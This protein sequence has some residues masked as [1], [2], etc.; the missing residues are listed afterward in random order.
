MKFNKKLLSLVVAVLVLISSLTAGISA[1]AITNSISLN[2][3]ITNTISGPDDKIWYSYTPSVSGTYALVSYSSGSEAYLFT[4]KNKVYNQ[5]AYAGPLDEDY[6]N[7]FRYFNGDTTKKH[8]KQSFYLECYLIKGVTYYF[9]AG[10]E[11]EKQ[12]TGTVSVALYNLSVDS[13]EVKFDS[14]SVDCPVVLSS[15]TDGWWTKDSVGDT[16]YYYN[17]S[18]LIQNM[19][20][21]ITLKDGT[22]EK[23]PATQDSYDGMKVSFEHAQAQNHWYSQNSDEYVANTL[24]VSIGP[25]SCDYEVNIEPSALFGVKLKVVDYV[26]KQ[27]IENVSVSFNNSGALKTDAKGVIADTMPAGT[28]TVTVKTNT[29]IDYSYQVTV[30]ANDTEQNNQTS[31]PV[32][33]INCDYVKDG[34]INAKDYAFAIKNGYA[35]HSSITNFTKANY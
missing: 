12:S 18:K 27:P 29:S 23:I 15:Y 8:I 32:K 33:L 11:Y 2:T 20:I 30:S 22:V 19:E 9:A 5:I 1:L 21:T 26:T 31:N 34:I 6:E 14:I 3:Y 16:Y 35:Y 24:K 13:D 10:F 28:Y 7:H 17:Y 4:K 25:V